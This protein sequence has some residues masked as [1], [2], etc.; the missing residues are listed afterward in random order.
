MLYFYQQLIKV[1]TDLWVSIVFLKQNNK[2]CPDGNK[3]IYIY[4]QIYHRV[5]VCIHKLLVWSCYSYSNHA[6]RVLVKKRGPC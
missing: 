5:S 6:H 4:A 3:N 1:S 2:I